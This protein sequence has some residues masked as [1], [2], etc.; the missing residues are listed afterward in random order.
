[1]QEGHT[2]LL[3]GIEKGGNGSPDSGNERSSSSDGH[4]VGFVRF[5][6]CRWGED[7]AGRTDGVAVEEMAG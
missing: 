7:G 3:V 4:R 5:G 2:N 6:R 1:M